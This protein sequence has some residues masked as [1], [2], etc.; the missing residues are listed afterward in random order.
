MNRTARQVLLAII[1]ITSMSRWVRARLRYR[2]E[3]VLNSLMILAVVA[4]RFHLVG[5]VRMSRVPACGAL[6]I[7]R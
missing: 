2:M 1:C 7:L 6:S 5:N 3:S 4:D